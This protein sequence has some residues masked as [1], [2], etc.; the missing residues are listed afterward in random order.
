MFYYSGQIAFPHPLMNWPTKAVVFGGTVNIG[1]GESLLHKSSP[2]KKFCFQAEN[3]ER[4][5]AEILAFINLT[6]PESKRDI[7]GLGLIPLLRL[8]YSHEDSVSQPEE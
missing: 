2:V 8:D 3:D 4:A 7:V 5:K 1:G 6:D